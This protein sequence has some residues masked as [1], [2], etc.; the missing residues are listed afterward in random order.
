MEKVLLAGGAACVNGVEVED[1]GLSP[2]GGELNRGLERGGKVGG[3][4]TDAKC[5]PGHPIGYEGEE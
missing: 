2:K 1:D 5:L 3:R 4:V